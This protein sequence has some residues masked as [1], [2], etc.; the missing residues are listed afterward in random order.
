MARGGTAGRQSP[1]PE[2][3]TWEPPWQTAAGPEVAAVLAAAGTN[4]PAPRFEIWIE[5]RGSVTLGQ[6]QLP[7]QPGRLGPETE[8]QIDLKHRVVFFVVRYHPPDTFGLG[9]P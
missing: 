9:S 1:K 2:Q 4:P 7:T 5:S 8:H 6:I 3:R